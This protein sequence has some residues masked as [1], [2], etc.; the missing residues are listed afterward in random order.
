MNGKPVVHLSIDCPLPGDPLEDISLGKWV[1]HSPEEL[2]EV[3][4]RIGRLTPE[5]L[6]SL[7]D[8]RRRLEGYFTSPRE[9]NMGDFLPEKRME[10]CLS[11]S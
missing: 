8:A 3:L 6:A 2:K 10:V 7:K 9:E 4:N 1:V 11:R 5:E